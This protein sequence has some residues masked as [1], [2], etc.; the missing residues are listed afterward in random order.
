MNSVNFIKTPLAAALSTALMFPA[1]AQA[2]I[3]ENIVVEGENRIGF[4]TIN[5][6]L[7]VTKGQFL[8]SALTKETI[9]RLYKTG[10][11]NNVAIFQRGQGELVI[12]VEERPSI[13]EV[14]IEGNKLIDSDVLKDALQ[15]LGI[16]QGRIYNQ[17]DLDRVIIDLKRRYQN[18][19][20]YAAAVTIES[21]ELARNRVNLT[22]KVVE[23]EP[24]SIGRISLVGNEVFSDR[25]LKS[26]MSLSENSYLGLGDSY[27]KPELEA[28]LEKIRSYYLD[29]GY[30][31]FQISSTQVSLSVDKTRVFT[32]I[33]MQEGDR[34]TL[35]EVKFTGE[36]ILT[37]SE[38]NALTDVKV[39]DVFSRS[40][41]IAAV[42]AVRERLSEE[43]YAFAEVT[44]DTVINPQDKTMSVTF[45]VEPKN[46]VYIRFVEFE[47]NTRSRDHV[48]RRELRQLESAP[49][50]LKLV[51]QSQSRL[52]RLGFF[53]SSA[54]E[55][56]RVSDDQV[57]LVVK[58]EEQATGSFTA[59]IG[60]S[61]VDGASFNLGLSERN[62][63]GSGNKL[64]L[65]VA[66]SAARKTA[67]IS[68]TNPY[69]TPD[70][71]SLGLGLYY[72]EIDAEELDIADFTTNN[73]GIS[74]NLGYP[75]DEN[76][77]LR[78]GVKVDSQELVCNQNFAFCFDYINEF[79]DK[80]NSVQA[81]LAWTHNSTN[82]FYFPSKG[83]KTSVSLEAVIP[84]TSDAPFY[85][86][87]AEDNLYL[88]MTQNLSLHFKG[89]F[90]YGDGYG[91]IDRLPFYENFY[92]GG[93]GTVRG[94]ESNSL[95]MRYDLATDG[96]DRPKG[97][98]T[99]VLGSIEIISPTPFIEDSSNQRIS[100][101]FD[102]GYVFDGIDQV[103]T[104]E[105]RASV[106][107]GYS[108]ITPVGPLTF[109]VAQPLN[110]QEG[111]ETQSFQ[112]TLGTAF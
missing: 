57:D 17:L 83:R 70:G 86:V 94:Y 63:I 110:D 73:Y 32:T 79:G 102:A 37:E 25:R 27:S 85:K 89:G 23:G 97:G 64:D 61:Q 10:F 3:V 19:G 77:S 41:I 53:K 28:D 14:K 33:N 15:G 59:G 74:A 7:P 13:N 76:N 65:Q 29:R 67:D 44:P 2:F 18:Q 12:K 30:A 40:K 105:L 96:S 93:I 56:K 90:A 107:I 42:N 80:T 26:Q 47:G 48:I 54:V 111:D 91:D 108:W 88:P 6:Y 82:S 34:F 55:T 84:G 4:E 99:R 75:I 36:T 103:E 92:A 71:V 58:I 95:G 39:G 51:R 62:F 31:Q 104:A 72:R 35:N 69:F 101:F 1:L 52:D 60:Y 20:Y 50:S 8:D 38:I 21:T 24:A 49:Y 98:N 81:T 87:F 11:F 9:E 46:R 100:W 16:K 112:F 78:Y 43:G 45:K 68:V 5:S 66:T 106:G 109:S 22:I